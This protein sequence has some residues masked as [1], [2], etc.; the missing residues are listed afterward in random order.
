MRINNDKG[1]TTV[2]YILLIAV[3]VV[4]MSSVFKRLEELII[5]DPNSLQN[6]FLSGFGGTI[7]GE[8]SGFQGRYERFI[9]KR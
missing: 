1:Q 8:N 3:V 2:E 6:S 9:V 7:E 4:V 5:T